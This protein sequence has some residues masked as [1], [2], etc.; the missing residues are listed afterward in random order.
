MELRI[1]FAEMTIE[2]MNLVMPEEFGYIDNSTNNGEAIIPYVFPDMEL[3]C[4]L[5]EDKCI[6]HVSED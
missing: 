3:E 5:E 1:S 6:R 4:V 2:R